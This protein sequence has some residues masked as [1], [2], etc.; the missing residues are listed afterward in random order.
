M[1][2]ALNL[3]PINLLGTSE[4]EYIFTS[5]ENIDGQQVL[6]SSVSILQGSLLSLGAE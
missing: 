6:I 1:N 4:G 5:K 2:T 3:I